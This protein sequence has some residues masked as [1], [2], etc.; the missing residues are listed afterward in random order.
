MKTPKQTGVRTFAHFLGCADGVKLRSD[1][2]SKGTFCAYGT[3]GPVVA[4]AHNKDLVSLSD[5]LAQLCSELL[6][7][8]ALTSA[9]TT[10]DGE[11]QSPSF[12]RGALG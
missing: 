10:C 5:A 8:R 12:G 3:A 4:L 6:K 11:V 7:R 9:Y 1:A 2:I